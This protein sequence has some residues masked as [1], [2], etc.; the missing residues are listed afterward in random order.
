MTKHTFNLAQMRV[1]SMMEKESLST[2]LRSK[3]H[4]ELNKRIKK[5]EM[6]QLVQEDIENV[7]D[8]MSKE[9]FFCTE[10]CC[11]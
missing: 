4:K 9:V 11:G 2:F 6:D 7:K 8:L 10:C 3:M 5:G 1:L